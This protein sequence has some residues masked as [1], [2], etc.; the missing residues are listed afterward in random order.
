MLRVFITPNLLFVK[1]V[2]CPTLLEVRD[3]FRPRLLDRFGVVSSLHHLENLPV[4]EESS[5]T[6]DLPVVRIKLPQRSRDLESGANGFER[7]SIRD[8]DVDPAELLVFE[9]RSIRLKS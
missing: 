2:W 9:D 3:A 6:I 4:D 1:Q 7:V 8:D 5:V